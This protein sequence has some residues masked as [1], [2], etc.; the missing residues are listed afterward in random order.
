M[1][2][3][4]EVLLDVEVSVVSQPVAP[5]AVSQQLRDPVGGDPT[6]NA[7]EIRSSV[8]HLHRIVPRT[9]AGSP[10]FRLANSL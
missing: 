7:P 5:P 4:Q 2:R 8:D 10:D 6:R 3:E 1:S 9:A